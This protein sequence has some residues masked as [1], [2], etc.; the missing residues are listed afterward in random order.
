[1]V[2]E[3]LVLFISRFAFTMLLIIISNNIIIIII[4]IEKYNNEEL[5]I[6]LLVLCWYGMLF[7]SFQHPFVLPLLQAFE[8]SPTPNVVLGSI[9]FRLVRHPLCLVLQLV[10]VVFSVCLLLWVFLVVLVL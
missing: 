4:I 1:M 2:S 6:C 3:R 10:L 7:P 9:L 8:V 5:F